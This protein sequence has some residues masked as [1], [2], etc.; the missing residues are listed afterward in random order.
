[1]A[2]QN[3]TSCQVTVGD[4]QPKPILSNNGTASCQ[5]ADQNSQQIGQKASSTLSK[6][7]KYSILTT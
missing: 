1:M 4:L 6:L 2:Q 5:L 3:D 7:N